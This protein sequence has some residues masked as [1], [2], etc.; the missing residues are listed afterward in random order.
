MV[1]FIKKEFVTE[2]LASADSTNTYVEKKYLKKRISAIVRADK[3]TAGSGTKGRSFVS[4]EG[5]LYVTRLE[6]FDYL[7]AN[8]A[9]EIMINYAM[10]VV[11]TLAAFGI[12]AKIKWPNDIIVNGRK[13]CGIL[14]K[15]GFCGDFVDYSLTGVGIN[16]NND[17][18]PEIK[19][20]AIS[21][22]QIAGKPFDLESVFFT[23]IKN[24]QEGSSIEE[25]RSYSAVIGK[26]IR[27]I[28]SSGTT[29][30]TAVSITDDGRLVLSDG[31]I[32]SAAELDLKIGF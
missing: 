18:A 24:V 9:F 3:Q 20:V 25:Y 26:K 22:K 29:E 8:R 4:A 32:L 5:G 21:M 6:F 1:D 12:D 2:H 11:K 10:G 23:F 28:R 30:E 17:I 27:V 7:P 16:V 14:I 19:D 15:N 31:E 13:I